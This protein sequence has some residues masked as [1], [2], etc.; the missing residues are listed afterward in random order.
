MLI[1]IPL[2]VAVSIIAQPWR[3]KQKDPPGVR[4]VSPPCGRAPF[5]AQSRHA[6]AVPCWAQLCCAKRA[7]RSAPS[8]RGL[9]P[10]AP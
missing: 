1:G 4:V 3:A 9:P 8:G 10:H 7:G 2:W 6:G 5:G